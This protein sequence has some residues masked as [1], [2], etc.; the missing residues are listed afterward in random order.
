MKARQG[1]ELITSGELLVVDEAGHE[2]PHDGQTIGEIVVR[3]NVVMQGY[4]NDP[5]ATADGDAR[6]LLPLP[7]TRR[8]SIRTATR[9][10]AT[11]SRT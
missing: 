1:V 10:F 4:Y 11:A 9:R 5:E 3:G 7:A 6:R 2:V 8:W